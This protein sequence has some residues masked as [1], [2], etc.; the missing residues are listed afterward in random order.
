MCV[1][2]NHLW[3]FLT[4]PICTFRIIKKSKKTEADYIF[5]CQ[6]C[7]CSSLYTTKSDFFCASPQKFPSLLY[8]SLHIE[9]N[10][11]SAFWTFNFIWAI[12]SPHFASFLLCN[13]LY[14]GHIFD[15]WS[16]SGVQGYI[17]RQYPILT[18]W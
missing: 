1:H 9:K 6:H 12:F 17:S 18:F 7:C 10:S 11:F 16:I 13:L 2:F 3:F 14:G 15:I 4:L 5:M 8:I